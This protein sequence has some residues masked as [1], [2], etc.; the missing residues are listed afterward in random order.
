MS[1]A[2][3]II[4]SFWQLC[5]WCDTIE[6]LQINDVLLDF[7]SPLQKMF[8]AFPAIALGCDRDEGSTR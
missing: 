1:K 8:G 4:A 6:Y 5:P 7:F 3:M 2:I